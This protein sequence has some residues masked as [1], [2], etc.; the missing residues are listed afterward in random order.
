MVSV[1]LVNYFHKKSVAGCINSILKNNFNNLEII[2]VNNSPQEKIG[3]LKTIDKRIKIIEAKKNLGYAGGCN[4]GFKNSSGNYL[5]FLNP[6]VKVSKNWLS[7]GIKP[8]QQGQAEVVMSKILSRDGKIIN[9][10]GGRIHYTGLSWAGDCGQREKKKKNSYPVALA[11][12][13]S[14]FIKKKLFKKLDGFDQD[15]F[16][17]A[18][19]ADLSLRAQLLGKRILCAPAS[20]VF[21]DYQFE[22]GNYK[23]YHLEKNRLAIILKNYSLKMIILFLPILVLFD[24]GIFLYFLFQGRPGI[25]IKA[26]IYFLKNIKKIL[27]Q[28]KLINQTRI[29]SDQEFAKFLRGTIDSNEINQGFFK[30]MFNPFFN[31]YWLLI[32][33]F[34]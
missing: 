22:K 34:L 19:D 15:F 11:S 33:R 18:E 31:F 20:L 12:G 17:Y 28:R 23:F 6:D 10:A 7:E 29:I 32:K 16:M 24:L 2:V 8:I 1:I 14:L 13:A 27:R 25:K 26:N 30:Y 9:S 5:I 3:Y 4:L 21:H